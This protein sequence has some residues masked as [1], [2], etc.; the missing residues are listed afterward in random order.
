MSSVEDEDYAA[1]VRRAVRGLGRRASEDP[2]AL[3]YLA[4][5]QQLVH[6]TITDS[7]RALHAAGFSWAEIA[8]PLGVTRQ[9]AHERFGGDP[10]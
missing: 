9:T 2:E 7:A 8:R 3:A 6:A 10:S 1:F 4:S 5:V